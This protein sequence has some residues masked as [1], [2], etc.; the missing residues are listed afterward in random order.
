MISDCLPQT[1]NARSRKSRQRDRLESF[2]HDRRE[3]PSYARIYDD[4]IEH[5]AEL[6]IAIEKGILRQPNQIKTDIPDVVS[7]IVHLRAKSKISQIAKA[8]IATVGGGMKAGEN[9]RFE[10]PSSSAWIF[11]QNSG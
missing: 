10:T 1:Q 9:G 3:E 11:F 6:G 8:T 7:S 4:V 2:D 5:M